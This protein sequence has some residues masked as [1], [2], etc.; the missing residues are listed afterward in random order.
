[1]SNTFTLVLGFVVG[2]IALI[3][4]LLFHIDNLQPDLIAVAAIAPIVALLSLLPPVKDNGTIKAI[5]AVVVGVAWSIFSKT[6]PIGLE[7]LMG[8]ANGL[9]AAGLWGVSKAITEGA[10]KPDPVV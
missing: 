7:I 1:M 9:M 3:A 6:G 2:A 8:V 5:L 4:K 10:K